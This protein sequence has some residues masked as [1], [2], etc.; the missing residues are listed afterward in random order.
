MA[1]GVGREA[2]RR[3][4]VAVAALDAGH[5][6]M[7]RRVQALRRWFRCGRSSSS[8]RRLRACTCRRTSSCSCRVG[9]AGLAVRAVGRHVAGVDPHRALRA[10]GR[11]ACRCG[12]CR[13]APTPQP[14][15]SWCRS[16]SSTPCCCG[17]CCTG[18]RSPGCGS[19]CSDPSPMVPL[20]QVEQ[21]VSLAA[22]V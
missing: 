5:R 7:G 15:G 13:T 19:S 21:F 10:L 12:S 22:W 18:R 3:V 8:C 17:S 4:V 2:R 9:V 16:R 1:H 20:W 6:D 11:V 14:Y